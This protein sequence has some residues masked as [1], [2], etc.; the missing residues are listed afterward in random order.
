M[1]IKYSEDNE[2]SIISMY[3]QGTKISEIAKQLTLSST[4]ILGFLQK[5]GLWTRQNS[6]PYTDK[7]IAEMEQVYAVCKS[8]WETGTKLNIPG[9]IV[10]KYL[11]LRGV[12]ETDHF[13]NEEVEEIKVEYSKPN[14]E[15]SLDSLMAR[16]NR[17]SK[18][19]ICRLAGELGLTNKERVAQAASKT[20]SKVNVPN[21]W[22][23][24]NHPKGFKGNTHSETAKKTISQKSVAASER[25]TPEE[26]EIISNKARVTKIEKYGTAGPIIFSSN[27]YSRCK[28][29]KREDLG[30]Y[31]F[32]SSWE[33]NY[34]RYL[35]YQVAL[36]TVS[37]WEFEPDTFIF[38]GETRG[39]ISYL[40]DFKIFNIDGTIEYHEIKGWM[41]A[42]SKSKLKKM[43]KF[44]PHIKLT[45]IG[46]KEYTALQKQ[47]KT[48]LPHWELPEKK[49]K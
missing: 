37:K 43:T 40:P 23:N 45:I 47:Y 11:T 39:A 33:A 41:D 15:F 3:Q 14:S 24:G 10:H 42:K 16:L 7:Q 30:N 17:T 27:M 8:V 13:S 5:K 22:E 38:T 31:F 44:Y 6:L 12:I 25:K 2:N 26:K 9:Q 29:G 19:G 49:T 35:N 36:K 20:I 28:R 34:A 46:Q 32:R 1:A 21:R 4:G 18:T 48:I